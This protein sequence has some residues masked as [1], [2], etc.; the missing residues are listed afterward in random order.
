MKIQRKYIEQ[1]D[2]L[3]ED[4]HIIKLPLLQSE[5]RGPK[6]VEKFSRFLLEPYDPEKHSEE[7]NS[8]M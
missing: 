4:M 3:Y 1:I 6:N 2:D 8:S 7:V 5:V